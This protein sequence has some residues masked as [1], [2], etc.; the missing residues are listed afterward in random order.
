[1]SAQDQ[2]AQDQ[3]PWTIRWGTTADATTRCGKTDHITVNIGVP[4]PQHEGPGLLAG[5]RIAWYS[6]DRREY[7]GEWPGHCGKPA[8]QGGCV[9]P[10]GH[11]GRCAP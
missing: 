6:G 11:P 9:L 5:Q 4:D 3:C 8:G 10:A 2:W 1:M 7:T